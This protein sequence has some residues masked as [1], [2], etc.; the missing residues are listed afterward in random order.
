MGWE[1]EREHR[2]KCSGMWRDVGS[3]SSVPAV[4]TELSPLSAGSYMPSVWEL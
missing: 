2:G 3:A 1:G 4:G